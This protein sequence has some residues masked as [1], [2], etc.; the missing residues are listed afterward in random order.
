M[1]QHWI[2]R[3]GALPAALLAGLLLTACPSAAG[4]S[5]GGAAGSSSAAF[6][7]YVGSGGGSSMT[8]SFNAS[9]A[10]IDSLAGDTLL[11]CTQTNGNSAQ[12]SV[13]STIP[14]NGNSFSSDIKTPLSASVTTELK[15]SGTLDGS[16]HATGTLSYNNSGVC[17]T[18]DS[19]MKWNAS[20][21]GSTVPTNLP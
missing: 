2:G 8:I 4:T 19:P 15:V 20:I 11:I 14:L 9:A 17:D 7:K 1:A 13:N 5:G 16:G 12:Y 21:G 10:G 3:M 6:G 18:G